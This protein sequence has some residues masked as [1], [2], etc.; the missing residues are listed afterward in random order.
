MKGTVAALSNS[1]VVFP[2]E[3]ARVVAPKSGFSVRPRKAS[4]ARR[5]L[6]QVCNLP[7]APATAAAQAQDTG[8]RPN[9]AMRASWL[10]M[11]EDRSW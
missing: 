6:W 7:A 5:G 10:V 9:S 1:A 8:V 3:V 4:A 2:R 11:V